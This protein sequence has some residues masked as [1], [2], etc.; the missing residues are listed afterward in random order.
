MIKKRKKDLEDL[1]YGKLKYFIITILETLLL[2]IY[3]STRAFRL[4]KADSNFTVKTGTS[5][6]TREIFQLYRDI[7]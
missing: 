3:T 1:Q 5:T 2:T 4:L 7:L 6:N